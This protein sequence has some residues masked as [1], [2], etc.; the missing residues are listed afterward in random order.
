MRDK[1][2]KEN[3]ACG[4]NHEP[5]VPFHELSEFRG[6]SLSKVWVQICYGLE[7]SYILSTATVNQGKNKSG[8][9]HLLLKNLD[10]HF[11]SLQFFFSVT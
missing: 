8:V 3:M 7:V 10:T 9:L 5:E 6:M 1:R 2:Q 11:F 4:F